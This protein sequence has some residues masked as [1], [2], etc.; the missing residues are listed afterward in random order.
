MCEEPKQQA[1]AIVA[2]IIT[3][4]ARYD[5]GDLSALD[6]LIEMPE[7]VL[8]YR[9]RYRQVGDNTLR[10]G[11]KWQI[12]LPSC[13]HTPSVRGWIGSDGRHWL[14]GLLF[15]LETGRVEEIT[16][17]RVEREA[18]LRFALLFTWQ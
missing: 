4:L 13:P 16:L 14:E 11:D 7:H 15:F 5:A 17:Q 8:V 6:E 2:E 18:L 3:K 1:Q 10:N 9:D 12:V